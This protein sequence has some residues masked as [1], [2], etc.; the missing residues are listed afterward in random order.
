MRGD[1]PNTPMKKFMKKLVI[2]CSG[3]AEGSS[4]EELINL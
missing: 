2:F 4:L 3:G 1:I